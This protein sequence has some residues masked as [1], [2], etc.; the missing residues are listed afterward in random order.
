MKPSWKIGVSLVALSTVIL[1][2]QSRGQARRGIDDES[3]AIVS[4]DSI[5]MNGSSSD[6][7]RARMLRDKVQGDYIWFERDL[8]FYYITD[9]ALVE[10]A[11]ELFRPQEELGRKQAELGEQQAKLGELQ[12]RVSARGDFSAQMKDLKRQIEVLEQQQAA[13]KGYTEEDLGEL[14]GKIGDLQ[15]QIGEL[16]AKVGEEQGKL[17]EE[18]GKLGEQQGKL[19]EEQGRLAEIASGKL[20]ELLDQA[21]HDGLAQPVR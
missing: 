17:G 20:R 1:I 7:R 10:R 21:I 8:K 6:A 5:T 19:G 4:G 15:G 3:Y 16:Q 12:A 9:P 18:Q 14:Q 11:K 2:A 13:H